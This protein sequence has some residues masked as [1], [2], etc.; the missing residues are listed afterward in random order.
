MLLPQGSARGPLIVIF[1]E[2]GTAVPI[3]YF[4]F[5]FNNIIKKWKK[6]ETFYGKWKLFM[7]NGTF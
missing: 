5:Y 1:G 7:E 3:F 4:W 2:C 6:I